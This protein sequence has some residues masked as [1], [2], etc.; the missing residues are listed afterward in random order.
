MFPGQLEP[1]DPSLVGFGKV[2]SILLKAD[3]LEFAGEYFARP[4]IELERR[5]GFP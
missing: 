4:G 2:C 5:D 1:A 3:R